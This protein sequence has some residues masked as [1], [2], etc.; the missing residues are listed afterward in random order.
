MATKKTTKKTTT[1]KK[2]SAPAAKSAPAK[3]TKKVAKKTTKPVSKVTPVETTVETKKVEETPKSEQ[4]QTAFTFKK[5][6]AALIIIILLIGAGMFYFRSLFVA[7]VVNNQPISRLEVV[8]MAEKQAGQQALDTL[9][10]DALIQQK[11]RE[12]NVTVSDEEIDEQVNKV[13]ESLEQQ[14]RSLD[15][16]LEAQGMS[17]DDL[18]EVLKLDRLVFKLVGKDVSV[19]EEEVNDY[20]E[21]N[22]ESFPEDTDEAELKKQIEEQL[23]QQK[24]SEKVRDWLAK[25]QEEANVTYF[26]QY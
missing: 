7:A 11:A 17:Q 14:G 4:P 23:K 15:Q 3:T 10:R 22:R 19:S 21:Q 6:Y 12:A 16:A 13:K 18:R 26:V 9:V 2:T 5:S 8:K 25:I 20:I 1:T 24:T